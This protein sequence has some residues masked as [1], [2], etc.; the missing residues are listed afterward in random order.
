MKRALSLAAVFTLLFTTAVPLYASDWDKVGKALAGIEGMRLLTGGNIDI[1]GTVTG[2]NARNRQSQQ[3]TVIHHVYEPAPQRVWV[4]PREVWAKKWVPEY[5]TYDDEL[6]E[7][8]V[9]GHYIKYRTEKEGYWTYE[10]PE[11]RRYR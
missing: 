5:T 3:R 10:R 11:A 6:G 8:V 9:E 4:P 1:L 7:I 2:M